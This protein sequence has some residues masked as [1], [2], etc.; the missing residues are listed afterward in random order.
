MPTDPYGNT[1]VLCEGCKRPLHEPA[2]RAL[3]RGPVCRKGLRDLTHPA[4]GQLA[5][6]LDLPAH[7]EGLT[8]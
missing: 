8:S 2:S 3:G 5:L 6:D 7:P 4:R 1:E